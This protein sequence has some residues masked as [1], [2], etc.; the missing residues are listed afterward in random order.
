MTIQI[1]A[2]EQY[3]VV[4][5]FVMP[6]GVQVKAIQQYFLV[7][8]FIM[9]LCSDCCESVDEILKSNYSNES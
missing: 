1:K 6:C 2:I 7:V 5:L 4:A 8:L 9:S 3:F